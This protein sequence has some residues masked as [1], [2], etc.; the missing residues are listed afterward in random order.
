MGD[1][2]SS[3]SEE[4]PAA[5][6]EEL[7]LV[8]GRP[9]QQREQVIVRVLAA[10]A[11]EK[12]LD[13]LAAREDLR[14]RC[15]TMAS[16]FGSWADF[17]TQLGPGTVAPLVRE[18]LGELALRLGAPSPHLEQARTAARNSL[19]DGIDS[20]VRGL[21]RSRRLFNSAR[22]LQ[23]A[24]CKEPWEQAVTAFAR[25][26]TRADLSDLIGASRT[27]SEERAEGLRFEMGLF[28][29]LVDPGDIEPIRHLLGEDSLEALLDAV[30]M[31]PTLD[32]GY[33]PGASLERPVEDEVIGL[34]DEESGHL[35]DPVQSDPFGQGELE[36][37]PAAEAALIAIDGHV[38]PGPR[39]DTELVA[40]YIERIDAHLLA[41][42]AEA[43]RALS[44]GDA[45]E[46]RYASVVEQVRGDGSYD[47]SEVRRFAKNPA[48]KDV[49][50]LVNRSIDEVRSLLS[51][52]GFVCAD[53]VF[54][55]EGADLA[56][57]GARHVLPPGAPAVVEPGEI[58][59]ALVREI[60]D[61]QPIEQIFGDLAGAWP[62]RRTEPF[63]WERLTAL[64]VELRSGRGRVRRRLKDLQ[65]RCLHERGLVKV[66]RD[67]HPDLKFVSPQGKR[68]AA[69]RRESSPAV[70]EGGR[71]IAVAKGA[72]TIEAKR[73]E[74]KARRPEWAKPLPGPL[75]RT[76]VGTWWFFPYG[77]VDV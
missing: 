21:V 51:R 10:R 46:R 53:P 42:V 19:L 75:A 64:V 66:P 68:G 49:A 15:F 36:Y 31:A 41:S 22:E 67:L 5:L 71:V 47:P 35:D 48:A 50:G 6:R 13:L 39:G 32:E 77:G 16:G 61:R 59:E 23:Q 29:E 40:E 30:G 18:A 73:S 60:I 11:R 1:L 17:P 34:L 70:V 20:H 43:R 4:L 38:G 44:E 74:A 57:L 9:L 69:G 24:V 76:H 7:L 54:E 56:F 45:L 63:D 65:A 2:G 62:P 58:A 27:I 28:P 25:S 3:L 12:N 14:W 37:H 26:L 33:R 72:I 8:T 52:D 55:P